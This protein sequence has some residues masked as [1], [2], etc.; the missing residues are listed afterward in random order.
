MKLAKFR[1]WLLGFAFVSFCVVPQLVAERPAPRDAEI[2]QIRIPCVTKVTV[3]YPDGS[4]LKLSPEEQVAFV[5]LVSTE[6]LE[7]NCSDP[8][9]LG[10]ACSLDEHDK[11]IGCHK[12]GNAVVIPIFN[13]GYRAGRLFISSA[14]APFR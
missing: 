8:I 14:G 1:P 6:L 5:F 7:Y 13:S 2:I 11:R 3:K 12:S 9:Y 10:R 4:E